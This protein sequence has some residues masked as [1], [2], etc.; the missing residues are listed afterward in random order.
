MIGKLI[1]GYLSTYKEKVVPLE[2]GRT[3]TNPNDETLI[4]LCGYKKIEYA[5]KPVLEE[6]QYL[7]SVYTEDEEKIYVAY[8]VKEYPVIEDPVIETPVDDQQI[9]TDIL[10]GRA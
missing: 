3:I 10:M 6:N 5:A 1:N 2:D 4:E 8:E 9:I 7:E